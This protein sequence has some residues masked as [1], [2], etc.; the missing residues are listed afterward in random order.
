MKKIFLLVTI[1]VFSLN[2]NGQTILQGKITDLSNGNPLIGV[3][4]SIKGTKLAAVSELDGTYQIIVPSTSKSQQLFV[5]TNHIGFNNGLAIVEILPIDDGETIVRNFELEPDPLTLQDITVTANRVEEELQDVPIAATVISAKDMQ[6]RTVSN[7]E[8][9]LSMVPN[10]VTDSY[11]P[12]RATFSLRGL[13]SDFTNLGVENSVGLYIDDVFYSRSF[14][15][16]QTLMDIERVEVLRGPQG[17]LFGKNTIGGVLHIISE[18]PKFDNFAAVELNAGNFNYLQLRGKANA[19]LVKNKVALRISGAYR[20]RDGWLLER[21]SELSDENGTTFYGGRASLLYKIND[22][23]DFTVKGTYTQ[24]DR[25]DF[26]IDYKTPDDGIDRIPV[27]VNADIDETISKDRKVFQNEDVFFNRKNYGAVGKLNA[28]LDNVHTLTS[29]T[30]YNGSESAFLRDFD[31]STANVGTFGKASEI[32]TFSQE[33]RITTPRE[34]RKFFY[35]GGLFFLNE[36]LSNTDTLRAREDMVPIWEAAIEQATGFEV[37]LPDDY[38]EA[39]YNNS[40]IDSKSYAAYL[41]TSYEFSERIRLNAGLRF[42]REEKSIDYY[43]GCQCIDFPIQPLAVLV[44]S[45]AGSAEAPLTKEITNNALSGNVGLD[46]KTT[47]KMLIYIN[48]ARGFKGAGFNVSLSPEQDISK[49]PFEFKPEIINSYEI[50][51]KLKTNN[52]FLFNAAAFVTD[53]QDKQEVVAVGNTV[54]VANAD[55]V[56]GQGA[57]VEFTGVWTDFF[58]TNVALG[59]LNLKY[60][61]FPF[62]NPFTPNVTENLSGNFALKAAPFTFKFSP[63]LYTQISRELKVLVRLDYNFVGKTY[64]DIFNTEG[65]AR[66]ATGTLNGRIALSTKNERF[67]IALWAKNITDE[68]YAQ[69]G[70]SFVFGDHIAINP[71]RMVG[72]ELRVNFY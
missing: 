40:Q 50:G 13:A 15:F 2:I 16:N 41:S 35:V 28:K 21:N 5:S 11:L 54:I 59:A 68:T 71:P 4:V 55:A 36:Q 31:A 29:I 63:E 66:E 39:V 45:P 18:Q 9:A 25:A 20:K 67:G 27:I 53:F 57:E 38:E 61:N 22:K 44:A 42:T 60:T 7:T 10:L 43:Q 70:W 23:I 69:H 52:R 30:A 3:F 72:M 32:N 24:D 64:N 33:L 14:N 26:T 46:F 62:D 37:N 34:N 49:L 65:L 51:L 56:Q 48:F 12:S 17:T 1:F 8:E 47:D 19:E 58:R 6:E